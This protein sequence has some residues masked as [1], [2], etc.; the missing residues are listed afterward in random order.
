MI[1]TLNYIRIEGIQG[2]IIE[3]ICNLEFSLG[4][5]AIKYTMSNS[6]PLA[7]WIVAKDTD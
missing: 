3:L 1:Y 7:P 2:E 6:R 4:I 5:E